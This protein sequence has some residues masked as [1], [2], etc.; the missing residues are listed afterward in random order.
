MEKYVCE[1]CVFYTKIVR[2]D[3]RFFKRK[4]PP[5]ILLAAKPPVG[6]LRQLFLL[7]L[8]RK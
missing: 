2:S 8:I 4:K 1:H 7:V 6:R 5:L 3:L